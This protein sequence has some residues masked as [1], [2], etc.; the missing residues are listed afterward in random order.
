MNHR[1]ATAAMLATGTLALA[2]TACG[3]D[4]SI[5]TKA[6][7]S[8]APAATTTKAATK[9]APKATA[10]KPAAA[11]IGD[12]ITLHGTDDGSKITV[13]II[14]WVDPAKGADEFTTPGT[15]KRFVAAQI[16]VTN[17]GTAV[18]DDTP[19]NGMQVA[20][21]EGQRFPSTFSEVS[22]GPPMASSVKLRTGDKAL[23]YVAFEVP[24]A[25]KIASV[26]FA[27]DSG[28]ADETGQWNIH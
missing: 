25:S 22:A 12:T 18:Y 8:A 5:N 26:Q 2:L 6:D 16:R 14:K 19:S 27:M 10:T 21:G 13:T 7:K 17:T 3:S 24:K 1:T 20:D 11:H 4:S 28:F 23:G 15:G 9:A